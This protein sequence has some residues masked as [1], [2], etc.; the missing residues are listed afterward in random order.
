MPGK[1]DRKLIEKCCKYCGLLFETKNSRTKYCSE[2]CRKLAKA[3]NFKKNCS[4]VKMKVHTPRMADKSIVEVMREVDE[5]N[6]T[7][8]KSLSYGQFVARYQK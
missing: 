7:H 5:Y 2:D 4:A 1:M 8:N 6:R 3:R